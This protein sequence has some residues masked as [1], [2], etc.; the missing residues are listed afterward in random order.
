MPG[1]KKQKGKLRGQRK[2]SLHQ[3]RKMR[4]IGSKSRM[5]PLPEGTKEAVVCLV[6]LWKHAAPGHQRYVEYF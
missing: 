4:H 2:L 6:G 5:H 1:E 3:S